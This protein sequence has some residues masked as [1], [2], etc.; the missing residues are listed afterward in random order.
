MKTFS[1]EYFAHKFGEDYKDFHGVECVYQIF[2]YWATCG[3]ADLRQEVAYLNRNAR[4]QLL[5]H[6]VCEYG[7]TENTMDAR[8]DRKIVI[9][10]IDSL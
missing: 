6:I 10:L 2:H 8:A 5:Q 7:V 3:Y 1:I 4:K 9:N